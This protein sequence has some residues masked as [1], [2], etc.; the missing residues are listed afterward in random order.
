MTRLVLAA[1][2]A[3]SGLLP[4]STALAQRGEPVVVTVWEPGGFTAGS[5]EAIAELVERAGGSSSIHHTG[6]VRLAAVT[7]GDGDVQRAPAGFHYPMAT[8]AIDPVQSRPMIGA[9]AAAALERG[10]VLMGATSA[11]LR[12]A[13]AGDEI[14]FLGWDG[15]EHTATIG[16]IV[17]DTTVDSAELVFDLNIARGF[18]FDRPASMTAWDVPD[19]ERLRADVLA[20]LNDRL[21]GVAL[22][23]DSPRLDSV[24]SSADLKAR[25]GEFAYRPSGRGDDIEIEP[26]WEQ[27]NIVTVDLPLLGTFKCHRKVVPYLQAVIDEVIREGLS[28]QIDPADFQRAGGCF[29]ARM[30]RGGDKGGALS[31]HAWGAAIDLNPSTNPYGG[32][33]TLDRRIAEIFHH[34]GFAWGGGWIYTDGGHFEWKHLPD[35]VVRA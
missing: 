31:R 8:L 1:L 5:A 12:G 21:I 23:S 15:R 28:G 35:H 6:T 32:A 4:G 2:V 7:R 26:G 16:L 18:G 27:A 3:L 11:R 22:S 30:I 34:W 25:F 29:N 9:G 19:A 14:S 33:I 17:D 20:V 13:E 24:S 10:E